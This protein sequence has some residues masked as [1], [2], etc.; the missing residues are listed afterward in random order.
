[1]SE[2]MEFLLN[3][4]SRPAK[5]L[6]GPGPDRAALEP[7]LRAGGRVP[8]HGKLEP[9]RFVVLEGAALARV[10]AAIRARGASLGED[11]DKA[12]KAFEGAP[13]AVIVVGVPRE[14]AKIPAQEQVLSV[15]CAAF[16]VL[17][18]ALASGWGANWLT[19]WV[20]RDPV[21]LAEQF[22]LGAAEWIAGFIHIGSCDTPV[23]ERPRP[24][25]AAITT[26]MS[27]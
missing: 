12:A 23:P 27:E 18:A 6:G 13:V 20:S 26:W 1:M 16:N 9:W 10:A 24:D 2:V 3:R 22:G 19:G 4:R 17:S 11:G 5:L 21:L 8:D 15:G 7:I 14:S 25:L